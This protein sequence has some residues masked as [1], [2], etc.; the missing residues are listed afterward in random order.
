MN[1]VISQLR[2][3]Q[4]T[5]NNQCYHHNHYYHHY[6]WRSACCAHACLGGATRSRSQLAFGFEEVHPAV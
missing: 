2:H 1:R 3:Y 5:R 6:R 4:Y